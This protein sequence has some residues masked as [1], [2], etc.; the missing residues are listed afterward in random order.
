RIPVVQRPG[1]VLQTEQRTTA[2]ATKP[3]V[4]ICLITDAD[5]LRRRAGCADGGR[6]DHLLPGHREI[7]LHLEDAVHAACP[8]LGDLAIRCAVDDAEE[9]RA[10]VLDDDV[11]GIDTD[12]LHYRNQRL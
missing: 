8:N 3:A 7:V 11:N 4:R 2:P 9:H 1:E 6:G 12:G 10:A 5:Q